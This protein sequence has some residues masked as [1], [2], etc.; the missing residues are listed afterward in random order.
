MAYEIITQISSEFVEEDM[1]SETAVDHYRRLTLPNVASRPEPLSASGPHNWPQ[2]HFKA[3]LSLQIVYS[4]TLWRSRASKLMTL[5]T[6]AH[7][8][9]KIAES[10]VVAH[11]NIK[12]VDI[13]KL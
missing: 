4:N 12:I 7:T 1:G 5:I 2:L 9:L 8:N 6:L 13:Y 3:R 10:H 11:P